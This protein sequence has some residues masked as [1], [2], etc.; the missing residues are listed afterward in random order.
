MITCEAIADH[1]REFIAHS[2][3]NVI[4]RDIA[5]NDSVVGLRLCDAPIFGFGDP[6]DPVF[7]ELNTPAANVV[8]RP[9]EWLPGVKTI[10]SFFLPFTEQVKKG[11]SRD[12]SYPSLE[13][14][15]ARIDGQKV[16]SALA[17][18]IQTFLK[19][20]GHDAVAPGL[21]AKF[22]ANY[23]IYSSNWSERHIAFVCG[24]GTF[25][26]SKGLITK[27]GMAGRFCSIL[28]TLALPPTPREYRDIY[29]YCN[30]CGV[31]VRNCPVQAISL[32]N[33]KAHQPCS[34]FLDDV[35]AKHDPYYG[36]GKCQVRVPCA[37]GVP[38]RITT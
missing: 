32:E 2:P 1:A 14:L 34:D 6:D 20:N 31:C 33:G 18:S 28:T 37:N 16:V 9:S 19:E 30:R 23:D 17:V 36:C 22:L 29:E 11:N 38:G 10:I 24:L 5:L 25:G 15:H 7:D 21:E 26:L 12:L 4:P 8:L 3:L 27:R 13:W 35:L